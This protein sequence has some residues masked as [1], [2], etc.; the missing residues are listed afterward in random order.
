MSVAGEARS[1][2]RSARIGGCYTGEVRPQPAIGV[3]TALSRRVLIG[4][5]LGC[6]V[7]GVVDLHRNNYLPVDAILTS[8]AVLS[9]ALASL[10][11]RVTADSAL[12][13][14]LGYF[15]I[16]VLFWRTALNPANYLDFIQAYLAYLYAILV[17][18]YAGSKA[19]KRSD[20]AFLVRFLIPL[21]ATKYILARLLSAG[22]REGSRPGLFTENNFE[23]VLLLGL[24]YL[25]YPAIT[26]GRRWWVA[27]LCI[28]VVLSES[29]CSVVELVVVLAALYVRRDAR[30]LPIYLAG[31]AVSAL[32][33]IY[34]FQERET[35]VGGLQ[36]IDR[37]RFFKSFLFDTHGW[38]FWTWLFGTRP[39]TPLPDTTCGRLDYYASLFSHG[40]PDKC[41]SVILH[42]FALRAVF[43]QGFIG[44]LVLIFVLSSAMSVAGAPLRVRL[45][46]WGI[47]AA[48]A[49]SVSSFNS[50]FMLIVLLFVVGMNY[51]DD[52]SGSSAR[53]VGRGTMRSGSPHGHPRPGGT[54]RETQRPGLRRSDEVEKRRSDA[55]ARA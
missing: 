28:V 15:G 53:M 46:V 40:D 36:S 33:V 35:G 21:F 52:V 16:K 10:R 11:F 3:E 24:F 51:D 30:R 2:T 9:V 31:T 32:A 38:H 19:F 22:L 44:V 54:S 49:A 42:A 39:I 4:A 27:A 45:C 48:N 14:A 25:A 1:A 17:A 6:A 26:R 41:Y 55:G 50:E 34:T 5:I 13:V 29:R 37:Y 12:V 47:G 8:A 18:L 43:D 20:A 7:A 23:L